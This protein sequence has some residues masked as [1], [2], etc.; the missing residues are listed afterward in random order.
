MA[1]AVLARGLG[2]VGAMLA[3][4]LLGVEAFGQVGV[5]QQTVATLGTVAGLGVAATASRFIAA[6]RLTRRDEAAAVL[7][8]TAAWSWG[9]ALLAGVGLLVSAPWVAAVALQAPQLAEPLRMAVPLLVFSLLAQAQA[10]AL[11]GFEAF[12]AAALSGLMAGLVA[13]PLQVGGAWQAGMPG[14]VLGLAVAEALRWSIGYR[15]L[16]V[17][18]RR[19]GIAWQRPRWADLR[20]LLGFGLPTMLAGLL[21]GPV[22]LAC[23]AVVGRQPQGYDEVGLFQATQQFRNLL[24]FVAV[25]SAAA[26]VPVLAA[27]HGAGDRVGLAR[28]LRRAAG[29]SFA[30]SVI[31][32]AALALL[33]P[34]AMAGFGAEFS[35]QSHLLVWLAVLAPAQALNAV[36]S[37]ALSAVDRPWTLLGA[38][39]LFAIGA[40]GI[41]VHA[42]TALGL[43]LS[44]GLASLPPCLWMLWALRREWRG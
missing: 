21:V 23:L 27:A 6:S 13:V 33:A 16:R 42:P 11:G 31:L 19:H 5:V 34:W 4:R 41:S 14:F 30:A 25:Q 37:S 43:V 22:Q 12:R 32:A 9:A 7:A 39:T 28:G 24:I 8:T 29:W 38:T 26:V 36:G 40:L 17:E 10:G 20:R 35:R 15:A 3:A 18:M 44:Q 2:L 1:S